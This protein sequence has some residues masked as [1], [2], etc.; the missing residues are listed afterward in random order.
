MVTGQEEK[1]FPEDVVPWFGD[2]LQQQLWQVERQ[3][4]GLAA[5]NRTR[6]A[7]ASE[8]QHRAS[9]L[10]PAAAGSR[11]G[12][13]SAGKPLFSVSAAWKDTV[14]SSERRAAETQTS[15]GEDTW[16]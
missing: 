10:T 7:N 3:P 15:A 11:N 14:F 5:T 8:L 13:S 9:G 6:E 16:C 12:L 4:H 2:V 1:C